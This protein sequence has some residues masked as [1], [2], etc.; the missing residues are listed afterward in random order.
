MS[1]QRTYYLA[2]ENYRGTA[3]GIGISHNDKTVHALN[4]I[5]NNGLKRAM[6]DIAVQAA[7]ERGFSSVKI[8]SIPHSWT[9]N[10]SAKKVNDAL[11]MMISAG[12]QKNKVAA[13]IYCAGFN[14]RT[15]PSSWY[16]NL[17][18]THIHATSSNASSG[19]PSPSDRGSPGVKGHE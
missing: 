5:K 6:E 11:H 4:G 19:S 17:H 14:P 18:A 8:R 9:M 12:S 3:G 7:I 10:R 16:N 13:H 2:P 15:R 1:R